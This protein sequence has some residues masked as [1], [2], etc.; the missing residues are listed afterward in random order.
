MRELVSVVA[1]TA[2]LIGATAFAVES[3]HDRETFVPPPDAVAEEFVHAIVMQRWPVARGYLATPV[4]DADLQE[5]QRH[6]GDATEIEAKTIT[7]TDDQ[8]LVTVRTRSAKR[9]EAVTLALTFEGGWKVQRSRSPDL[10]YTYRTE[11]H[12]LAP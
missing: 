3:M 11:S 1:V 2:L 4:P 5:L 12:T 9:S 6:I 7:R 10:S 8:A